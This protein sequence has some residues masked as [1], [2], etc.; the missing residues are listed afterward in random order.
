MK[1]Q[2]SPFSIENG[3]PFAVTH[4]DTTSNIDYSEEHDALDKNGISYKHNRKE[5]RRLA[6]EKKKGNRDETRTDRFTD[7]DRER[8][9]RE[10]GGITW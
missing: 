8:A 6:S 10:N 7:Q 1:N 4:H 3:Y 2:T 5:R 9:G